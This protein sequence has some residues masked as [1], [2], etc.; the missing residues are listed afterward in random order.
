MKTSEMLIIEVM[1]KH[2]CPGLTY[3]DVIRTVQFVCR[4]VNKNKVNWR[5][6]Q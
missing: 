2:Y 6:V 1:T 3:F 5:Q 4:C